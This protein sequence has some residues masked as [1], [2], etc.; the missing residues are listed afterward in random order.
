MSL[1]WRDN[2]SNKSNGMCQ[3]S[4]MALALQGIF[5]IGLVAAYAYFSSRVI[6]ICL[7]HRLID[8]LTAV[9]SWGLF[10]V[11]LSLCCRASLLIP[12]L[13]SQAWPRANF[14][15][16]C[17]STQVALCLQ[18]SVV[19]LLLHFDTFINTATGSLCVYTF[20]LRPVMDASLV[21]LTRTEIDDTRHEQVRQH[22]PTLPPSR[23][24]CR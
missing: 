3:I 9:R 24:W 8:V 6:D 22:S 20:A 1:V 19:K 14:L 4:A 5:M 10:A 7:N 2:G 16:R 12:E 15:Q 23:V 11:V 21:P 13:E 18:E 17:S